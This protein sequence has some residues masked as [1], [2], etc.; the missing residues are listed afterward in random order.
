MFLRDDCI[1][2]AIMTTNTSDIVNIMVA[3]ALISGVKP[4][5]MEEYISIGRVLLPV[6]IRK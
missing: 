5:L 2:I 1:N 4:N 3:T 6:G